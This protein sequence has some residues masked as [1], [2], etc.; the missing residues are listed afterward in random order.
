MKVEICWKNNFFF[1]ISKFS[2][3]EIEKNRKNEIENFDFFDF[4]YDFTMIFEMIFFHDIFDFF[5]KIFFGPLTLKWPN[6]ETTGPISKI[7]GVL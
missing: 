6:S 5:R 4:L 3:F 2:I 1:E 7:V